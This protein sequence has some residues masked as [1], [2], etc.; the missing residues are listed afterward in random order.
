VDDIVEGVYRVMQKAQEK[1]TGEDGLP[2]PPYN[3][4]NIGGG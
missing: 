4:Y 2:I 3:V 1:K